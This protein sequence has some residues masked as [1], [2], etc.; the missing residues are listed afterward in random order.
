M[1]VV[2]IGWANTSSEITLVLFTTIAPSSAF[3]YMAILL[4]LAFGRLTDE[5]Y[6]S[7]RKLLWVP[8]VFCMAGLIASATHLGNPSNALYVLSRVGGSPL[9]NEVFSLAIF[10]TCAALYWLAGFAVGRKRIFDSVMTVLTL[11]SGTISLTLV[12]L[13]Y[14]VSTI[15][16]WSNPLF[17]A[18]IVLSAAIAGPLFANACFDASLPDYAQSCTLAR[19]LMGISIAAGCIW[20]ILHLL[21]AG[22]FDGMYNHVMTASDLMPMYISCLIGASALLVSAWT[23]VCRAFRRHGKSHWRIQIAGIACA[24]ASIFIMRL[25]FYMLHMTVG[26][27]F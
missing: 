6:R 22:E 19:T 17:P 1:D 25:M 15:I 7:L 10:L 8:L 2:S 27:S 24:F 14:S 3:A 16:T 21:L 12:S 18:T 4:R 13:A 11:V 5:A 23:L 9:S 20:I 26:L